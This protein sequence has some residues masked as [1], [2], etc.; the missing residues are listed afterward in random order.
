MRTNDLIFSSALAIAAIGVGAAGVAIGVRAVLPG[1]EGLARGLRVDG[2]VVG[3]GEGARA[4]ADARARAILGRRVT[5]RAGDEIVSEA[6]LED[7]GATVDVDAVA[8]DA[9]AI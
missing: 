2:V 4:V 6:T 3:E 1:D 8:K 7:L 9:E 5:L